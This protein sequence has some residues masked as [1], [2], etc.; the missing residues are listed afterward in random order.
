MRYVA[1]FQNPS[2]WPAGTNTINE[3]LPTEAA[4]RHASVHLPVPYQGMLL[5]AQ[6][7]PS[8]S[9]DM[10]ICW[11]EGNAGMLDVVHGILECCARRR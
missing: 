4:E 1:F 10:I 6:M 8:H 3:S 7:L 11:R 5:K 9:E 2:R